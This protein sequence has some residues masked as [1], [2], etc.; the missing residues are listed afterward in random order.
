[1]ED[2]NPQTVQ[3]LSNVTLLPFKKTEFVTYDFLSLKFPVT[4]LN[5]QS[6][7]T[8][9]TNHYIQDDQTKLIFI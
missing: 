2:L 3:Y 8:P 6:L 7:K 5:L 4:N 1:M 9:Q